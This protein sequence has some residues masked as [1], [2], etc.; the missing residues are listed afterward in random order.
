MTLSTIK[1]T[2]RQ[3]LELGED[4]AG[5]RL[6]LANGEIVM[7][8][9]P[10]PDHSYTDTRLRRLLDTYVESNDLG[11]VFGDVDTIFGPYD[12]RRPDVIFF[13]KSRLHLISDKAMEGPP[14]LCVEILSPSSA[15]TDRADKFELYRAGGVAHYW[16][17]DP[18]AQSI[19]IQATGRAVRSGRTREGKRN[20]TPA[21]IR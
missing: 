5:I 19:S 1:M 6:E 11:Q 17:I 14:D 21:A 20:S 3:F 7:S 18:D 12:V 4:P 15:K 13:Q 16:I 10:S 9:S 8:P 2:A